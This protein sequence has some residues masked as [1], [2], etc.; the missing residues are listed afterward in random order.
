MS[1]ELEPPELG[2][3][4]PFQ[5]EVSQILRLRNPHS[6]PVAFKVKTTAPKQYCVR[7]N[8]GRIEPG[9]DVE[10]KILLQAMK[11]D[12]PPDAKCRDKFLVQSV[13]ITAD[14]EFTNV[15]SLWSHIEQTN[16]QSIQEKKIRVN[17]LPADAS[18]ATP[19][20]H[21]GVSQDER[22]LM[23]SASPEAYTPQPGTSAT[24]ASRVESTPSEDKLSRGA[25]DS[26]AGQSAAGSLKSTIT[27]A[28][29]GV[30]NA[31]PTSTAEL[32]AQLA[33]SKAT[34]DRLRQQIEQSTGLR[35]RKTEATEPTRE[36]NEQ[37]LTAERVQPPAGG[38]PVQIVA[39]LCL[40]SFLLA[41][42]LF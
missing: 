11:E 19:I 16:K 17:F 14:K 25:L 41:Y 1:V 3:K 36:A 27:S 26:R 34:I 21:H 42:F 40:L 23:S 28:A 6:D 30:A 37:L 29:A 18:T 12:P 13:L 32:Q 22:S 15:A 2:F 9:Q 20:K 7:P 10:V 5:Q 33:E 8:S 4:R 38:V 31:I 24:P 35:Q 39:V